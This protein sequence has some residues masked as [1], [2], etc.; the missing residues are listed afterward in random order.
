MD[1]HQDWPDL[2]ERLERGDALAWQQFCEGCSPDLLRFVAQRFAPCLSARADPEDVV[3]SIFRTMYRRFTEGKFKVEDSAHLFGLLFKIAAR[4]TARRANF[5]TADR[6]DCRRES[7]SGPLDSGRTEVPLDPVDSRPTPAEQVAAADLEE[8]F[9]KA[10]E[11]LQGRPREVVE[12]TLAGKS[13]AE[14]AQALHISA[15]MVRKYLQKAT[16]LLEHKLKE[17]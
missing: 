16:D 9:R 10:V 15:R 17:E 3:Q 11:S 2:I 4:K 8:E 1:E 12:L 14:T 13:T 6:R 5:E 7:G